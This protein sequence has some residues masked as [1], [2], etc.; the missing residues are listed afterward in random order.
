MTRITLYTKDGESQRLV[1]YTMPDDEYDF[2]EVTTW[3]RSE[4]KS[5]RAF[6]LFDYS[7]EVRNEENPSPRVA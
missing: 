6:I 2:E 5:D 7:K 4:H 3:A 1:A